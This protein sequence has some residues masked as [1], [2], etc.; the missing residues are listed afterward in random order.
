MFI[1]ALDMRANV[2]VQFQSFK[3]R[4]H[5]DYKR[6]ENYKQGEFLEK[7]GIIK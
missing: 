2:F 6:S 5:V 1:S 3:V 7:L 4:I